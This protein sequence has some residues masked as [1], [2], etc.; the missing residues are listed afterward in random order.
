VTFGG[1]KFKYVKDT[2]LKALPLIKKTVEVPC[3]R[4]IE[5]C[6][7]IFGNVSAKYV[8]LCIEKIYI[9]IILLY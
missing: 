9:A 2:S 5:I 1:K 6:S 4:L 3:E 7:N 8:V